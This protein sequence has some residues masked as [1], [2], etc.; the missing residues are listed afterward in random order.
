M[1]PK[2]QVFCLFGEDGGAGFWL[3][4]LCSHKVLNFFTSSSHWI[5]NMFSIAPHFFL[6]FTLV[7]Y[8]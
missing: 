8:I 6:S 1:H 4:P 3:S 7:S 5:S 2:G